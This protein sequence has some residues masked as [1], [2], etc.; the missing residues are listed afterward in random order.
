MSFSNLI[1]KPLIAAVLGA[2]V[3]GLPLGTFYVAG[4]AHA[5]APP[6]PAAV[7]AQVAPSPSTPSSAAV[8]LPDFSSMVQKY[9]PA[10]VNIQV[11]TKMRAGRAVA[12]LASHGAKDL[13][14][15]RTG[16]VANTRWWPPFCATVDWV[17]AGILTT[18]ILM[19]VS[20]HG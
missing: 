1:R 14:Q 9:G 19:G 18:A 15:H 10:V 17:A 8:V 13:W 12:G 20:F 11:V 3:I 6:P 16:Y 2:A 5:L 7:T 4:A